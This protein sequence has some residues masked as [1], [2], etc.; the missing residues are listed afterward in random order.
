MR[1]VIWIGLILCLLFGAWWGA[2]AW[3]MRSGL[4][5]WFDARRGEGWQAEMS[6]P[7]M[8]G[9]PARVSAELGDLALTD[10]ATGLSIAADTLGLSV[11]TLWPGDAR[12]TLPATPIRFATPIAAATLTMAEGQMAMALAPGRQLALDAL[13]WT[14]GPWAIASKA[15]KVLGAEGLTLTKTRDADA[16]YRYVIEA[17]GF[18]PGDGIRQRLGV[19]A[20]VPLAFDTLALDAEV[21]YDRPWD[22]R[23]LEE[24]RPQPQQITL[25]LAEARWGDLR[26]RLSADVTVDTAGQATGTV[27]VQAQNW[28]VMLD[29]A[30]AGG[31]LPEALRAQAE[32]ILARLAAFGGNPTALDLQLN[33]ADGFMAVG[34]FPVGKIPP[35]K[36]P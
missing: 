7:R 22:L 25:K 23:A 16:S 9:F 34:I 20:D 6:A 32:G 21:T 5:G 8:G 3:G 1:R 35:L 26:L 28:P 14:S 36:I 24:R 17:A 4:I 29:L 18:T 12:V 2:A 10:P 15:G 11:R 30:V 13:G 31:L 19:A 27:N 33:L